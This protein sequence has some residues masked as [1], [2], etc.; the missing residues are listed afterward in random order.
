MT[1]FKCHKFSYQRQG[2]RFSILYLNIFFRNV[3][4]D[5]IK[6]VCEYLQNQIIS[7]IS[8]LTS[9]A[10]CCLK[11]VTVWTLRSTI[12]PKHVGACVELKGHVVGA[13]VFSLT[14][15]KKNVLEKKQMKGD[16]E[17]SFKNGP[18]RMNRI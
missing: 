3:V 10:E 18:N 14:R 9:T 8:P 6:Y 13:W 17:K 7:C 2:L 4:I 12:K 1:P 16:Q 5:A 11:R 15:R